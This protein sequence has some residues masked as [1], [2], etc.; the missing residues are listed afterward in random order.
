MKRHVNTNTGQRFGIVKPHATTAITEFLS[1]S[2][3]DDDL[4]ERM[5]A[6]P[7]EFFL[8]ADYY[9]QVHLANGAERWTQEIDHE[10]KPINRPSAPDRFKDTSGFTNDL[11]NPLRW[12]SK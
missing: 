9:G 12:D 6:S 1:A 10:V 3:L 5:N 2:E 4:V 7:Q 8:F 11:D